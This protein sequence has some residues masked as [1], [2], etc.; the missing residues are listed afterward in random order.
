MSFLSALAPF[1]GPIAGLLGAGA[2]AYGQYRANTENIKQAN[3]QMEFQERM[4]NTAVSRRMQD[5]KNSG[6]NPILAGKFDA[7]S[8]AGAMAN[9]GSVGGAAVEGAVAAANTARSY[10]TLDAELSQ[11]ESRIALNRN[12]TRAL[13]TLATASGNAGDF[14]SRILEQA[15]NFSFDDIDWSNIAQE[16]FGP[17]AEWSK[18]V[19]QSWK[20]LVPDIDIN[21]SMPDIPFW[22]TPSS[23]FGIK[24]Q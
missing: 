17:A 9:I 4:S 18:A 1:A 23:Q 8:P 15:K 16:F 3:R 14:L 5:L 19:I 24:D 22:D 13:E 12:Q 11:I 6:I 21:L 20:N 7:S 2:S 10:A